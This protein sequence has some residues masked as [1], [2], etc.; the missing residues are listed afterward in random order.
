MPELTREE[1]I[2]RL[3][4]STSEANGLRAT[5]RDLG[6]SEGDS[7]LYAQVGLWREKANRSA[8]ELNR[9]GTRC[10]LAERA[11]RLLLASKPAASEVDAWKQAV[12]ED[13][14]A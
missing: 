2:E 1:I 11:L 4:A 7:S 6:R 9:M 12:Q 5:L 3:I 8:L 10:S 13:E 14:A